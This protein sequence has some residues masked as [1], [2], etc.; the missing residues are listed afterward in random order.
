MRFAG[1]KPVWT[2]SESFSRW[3]VWTASAPRRV[4]R[5]RLAALVI[6]LGLLSLVIGS[7]TSRDETVK[8]SDAT[9]TAIRPDTE[10]KGTTIHLYDRG[11]VVSTIQADRILKY[12]AKDSTMGYGVHATFF[13]TSGVMSS[14][15][16][17]DSALIREKT[18]RQTV[19][20]HVLIKSYDA[21]GKVTATATGDSAV[22]T[23][24]TNHM[25]LYGQVVVESEGTRK[26]E[27]DYLHWNPDINKF[28]TDAFVRF[29]QGNSVITGWGAEADRTLK[30]FKI[31]NKVSGTIMQADS[32]GH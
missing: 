18:I 14:T 20:G 31:L 30:R 4:G 21:G 6:G 3:S 16:V 13:D 32:L 9:D 2:G 12:E 29:T 11:R 27:T 15:L 8:N 1:Q 28:Q 7:C 17:G 24:G 25:Q 23:E 19:Y 26:L 22:V 10:L 5:V